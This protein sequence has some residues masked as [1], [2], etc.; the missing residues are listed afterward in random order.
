[1]LYRDKAKSISEAFLH[2]IQQVAGFSGYL[3]FLYFHRQQRHHY[4]NIADGIDEETY[5]FSCSGKYQSGYGR[6]DQAGSIKHH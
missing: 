6:T 2:V 3:L 1:M 5:P 4:K